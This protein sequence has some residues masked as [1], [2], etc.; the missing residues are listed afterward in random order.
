MS[1][2]FDTVFVLGAHLFE[3]RQAQDKLRLYVAVT[4]AKR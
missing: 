1:E 4:R 2:E 3:Q